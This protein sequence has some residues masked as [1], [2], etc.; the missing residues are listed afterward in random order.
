MEF[1]IMT[2]NQQPE[3]REIR[4]DPQRRRLTLA[5][6]EELLPAFV[7]GA[8][9][10]EE[11][12]AVERFVQQHPEIRSRLA[13][14]ENAVAELAYAAP[15]LQPPA[16]ARAQLMNRVRQDLADAQPQ[17]TAPL[18]S[19]SPLR[20]AA[21]TAP[22]RPTP[23]QLPDDQPGAGLGWFGIFWRTFAIAGAAAAIVILA[24]LTLQL[25]TNVNQLTARLQTLQANLA[26][27]QSENDRL[28]QQNIALQEQ[29]QGL[30]AQYQIVL[31]PQQ[32]I[33]L[34]ASG[35]VP[36]ATG[37]FYSSAAQAVLVLHGLQPLPADQTYQL[38][39]LSS[40]GSAV[41]PGELLTV[42]NAEST[43]LSL[44]IPAEHR[45]FS[46]I[47]ISIE[48]AGGRQTPTTVVLLGKANKTST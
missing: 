35:P 1:W 18:R 31:N 15:Q 26:N 48:P 43:T 24:F 17:A 10:P 4:P 44:A 14:Y 32:S 2:F 20:A 21:R 40:D 42:T 29:I 3:D 8:L 23:V 39:W 19:G 22:V 5:E 27:L 7:L 33:A 45:D 11:M 16:R 38:W 12:L 36:N 37:N 25:R 34:A 6:A 41:L 47:G 30:D 46:G 9:E 28:A 13:N